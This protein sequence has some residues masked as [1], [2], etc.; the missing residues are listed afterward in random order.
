MKTS[1]CLATFFN[2]LS[3]FAAVE[4]STSPYTVPDS[5]AAL[6]AANSSGYHYPTG[7]YPRCL[8]IRIGLLTR[9]R[10]HHSQHCSEGE[11]PPPS[12]LC[13][14]CSSKRVGSGSANS[15]ASQ[16]LHSHNDYVRTLL[17]DTR[18]AL[19]TTLTVARRPVLLGSLRRR[20]LRGSR[21]LAVQWH[22]VHWT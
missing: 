2:F 17:K 16:P 1:T 20:C 18:E 9:R 22:F 4:Y 14:L 3:A 21:C 10:R 11:Y 8:S 5:L 19:L 12:L 15:D 13:L 6:L 7:E